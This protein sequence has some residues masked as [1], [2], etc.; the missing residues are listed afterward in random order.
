MHAHHSRHRRRRAA[1][2]EGA[3]PPR[4][5]DHRRGDFGACPQRADS[6]ASG[7]VR[8]ATKGT[9]R[10]PSLSE[11]RRS[12]YQRADRQ[13]ARRRRVLMRALLDENLVD[14]A[15]IHGPRQLTDLYLLALALRRGGRFATFD[16]PISVEAIK[17]AKAKDMI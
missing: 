6:P 15:R 2:G 7:L 12:C 14:A 3:R 11:A 5:E 4:Q 1:G 13:A 17:E 10:I 9:L 16:H 8:T